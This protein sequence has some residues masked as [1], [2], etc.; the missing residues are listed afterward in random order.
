MALATSNK[1]HQNRIKFR[2]FGI[3]KAGLNM[4]TRTILF[5]ISV[6]IIADQSIKIVINS[7]FLDCQFDIIPSF[8]EFKPTFNTRHSWV[9]NLIDNNFG[10]NV[11]LL[12][13]VILYL[14][15]GV[16]SFAYYSY[17]RNNIRENTKLLDTSIIFLYAVLICALIGNLVWNRGTLDYIYLKPLFVFDLKD[18]YADA[19]IVLFMIYAIK[20][21]TQLNLVKSGDVFLYLKNRLKKDNK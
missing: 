1:A 15:I 11:G 18:T 13:H 14:L 5:W 4:R 8:L 9:N 3:A 10:L 12:P 16:L 2:N 7:Y 6:L 19:V 17:Y 20:N 21:R